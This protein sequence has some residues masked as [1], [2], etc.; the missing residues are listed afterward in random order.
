M[1]EIIAWIRNFVQSIFFAWR[2]VKEKHF[3]LPVCRFSKQLTAFRSSCSPVRLFLKLQ[4][5]PS[6]S[7]T[8]PHGEVKGKTQSLPFLETR[9]V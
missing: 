2:L 5:N 1:I 7:S 8:L 3:C 4:K 6:T 9:P